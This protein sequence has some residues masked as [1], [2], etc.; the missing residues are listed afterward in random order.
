ME[1]LDLII[2]EKNKRIEKDN[3]DN[4]P[5]LELPLPDPKYFEVTENKDEVDEPKRVIIIDL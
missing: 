3:I 5:F 4:R 1:Y 2:A